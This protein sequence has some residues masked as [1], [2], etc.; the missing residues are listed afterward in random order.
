MQN[1]ELR[2]KRS[3]IIFFMIIYYL[4]ITN[5]YE[6]TNCLVLGPIPCPS[7][8]GR[9][10]KGC[11]LFN[12]GKLLCNHNPLLARHSELVELKGKVVNTRC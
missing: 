3:A 1:A 8:R 10:E 7:P 9:V 11:T 5:R 12:Y 4:R 2:I 6:F